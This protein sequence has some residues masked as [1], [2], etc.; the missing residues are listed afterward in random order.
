MDTAKE[1]DDFYRNDQSFK[2]GNDLT[3]SLHDKYPT[4]SQRQ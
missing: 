2:T 4:L 3:A 1:H